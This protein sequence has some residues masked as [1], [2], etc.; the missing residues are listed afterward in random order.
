MRGIGVGVT[1]LCT[2]FLAGCGLTL[3]FAGS[4]SSP[5]AA[6][7]VTNSSTSNLLGG[8]NGVVGASAGAGYGVEGTSAIGIGVIGHGGDTGA[9]GTSTSVGVHGTSEGN[10]IGV[11]G[12]TNTGTGVHGESSSGTAVRAAIILSGSGDLFVGCVGPQAVCLQ[13][14]FRVDRNGKV[15]ADGGYVTGG[16]DVAEAIAV[17]GPAE[18]GDVIEIDRHHPDQFRRAAI[19]NS[20]A[21]AG[22]ISTEPGLTLNIAHAPD[23]DAI[24]PHLALAGR[25]P[26]KV[27]AEN[28]CIRP[29]DLLVTSSTPGHAMRAPH[30][31]AP[32]TVIGKALDSLD[33]G[34]GVISMLITPR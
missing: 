2:S 29:G 22:V 11:I 28:G 4:V 21:V 32:G 25:T 9:W 14:K 33:S 15:F 23:A 24:G 7:S 10:G 18:P 3:P 34:R 16:A 12:G 20:T 30:H 17:S 8:P 27:S 19:R 26:V 13:N 1:V 31:P 6:F 5:G